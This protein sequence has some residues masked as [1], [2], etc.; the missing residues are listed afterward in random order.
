VITARSYDA[1]VV[2]THGGLGDDSDYPGK[3]RA[4][5]AFWADRVAMRTYRAERFH[6]FAYLIAELIYA[7]MWAVVA[8]VTPLPA[9]VVPA[10]R[11]I[12]WPARRS[13]RPSDR[14]TCRRTTG[15]PCLARPMT[16]GGQRV[17]SP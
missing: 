13:L 11:A 14:L 12:E 4:F 6:G 1:H 9:V 8:I 16:P 7:A 15:P 2:W 3:V 5:A 17:I 10:C